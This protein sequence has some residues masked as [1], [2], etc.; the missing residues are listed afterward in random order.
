MPTDV[1]MLHQHLDVE[2]AFVDYSNLVVS[3]LRLKLYRCRAF[4]RVQATIMLPRA[5]AMV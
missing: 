5:P 2:N 3:G 4:A 1:R